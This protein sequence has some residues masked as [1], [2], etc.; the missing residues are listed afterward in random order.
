MSR[1]GCWTRSIVTTHI[2]PSWLVGRR[3]S[4]TLLPT[5]I[6]SANCHRV[7]PPSLLLLRSSLDFPPVTIDRTQISCV[8]CKK[9]F[10]CKPHCMLHSNRESRRD[11]HQ[12]LN[13][14]CMH[15]D[16]DHVVEMSKSPRG[17]PNKNHAAQ[18]LVP[19]S[20][21]VGA[22][23][24]SSMLGLA[25]RTSHP[26]PNI[27]PYQLKFPWRGGGVK[28][29]W[30]FSRCIR[31]SVKAKQWRRVHMTNFTFFCVGGGGED[32]T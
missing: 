20:T 29:L 24:G 21:T 30:S 17:K 28:Y 25:Y 10:H 15:V 31:F 32:G 9:F 6:P 5:R 8:K 23:I 1:K 27:H 2:P 16:E 12:D 13:K 19:A 26:E 3:N 7:V 11:Q 18:V 4:H 14:S 22:A